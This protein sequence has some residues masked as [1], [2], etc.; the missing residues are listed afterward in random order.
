[1]PIKE[2]ADVAKIT[3]S[4]A[5]GKHCFKRLYFGVR[6]IPWLSA[7]LMDAIFAHLGSRSGQLTRA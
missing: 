1:M 4:T 7:T 2:E 6:S 3:F 5:K